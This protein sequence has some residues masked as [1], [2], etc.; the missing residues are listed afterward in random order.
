M[1]KLVLL[2][3]GQGDVAAVP[4][5]VKRLFTERGAWQHLGLDPLPIQVGEVRKL[6]GAPKS[7]EL[8]L[9]RL[10]LAGLRPD[11][12]AILL[13][14]DGDADAVEGQP[15]CAVE[16]ARRLAERAAIIGAGQL[17]SLA[18]VFAIQEFESWL[19]AAVESL[20]G[21][22]LPDGRPASSRIIRRNLQ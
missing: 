12:G 8:W 5:L 20:A 17:F 15:F 3:E 14:L 2:V 7:R 19:I 16:V 22:R 10:K 9:K 18:C 1:K 6:T 13:V 4:T 21:K 11:T